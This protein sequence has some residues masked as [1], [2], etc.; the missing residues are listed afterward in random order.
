MMKRISCCCAEDVSADQKDKLDRPIGAPPFSEEEPVDS[1]QQNFPAGSVVV[2]NDAASKDPYLV[3]K[4]YESAVPQAVQQAVPQAEL[5]PPDFTGAWQ[6]SKNKSPFPTV[7][8][9]LR[10]SV[11]M[12]SSDEGHQS[13]LAFSDGQVKML[14]SGLVGSLDANDSAILRW[15]DGDTWN[16]AGFD[17]YWQSKLTSSNTFQIDA[18]KLTTYDKSCGSSWSNSGL[19]PQSP[20]LIKI[21]LDGQ[22]PVT[23]NL[24]QFGLTL[25]W[26]DGDVWARIFDNGG[27]VEAS[28]DKPVQPARRLKAYE[29]G[30]ASPKLQEHIDRQRAE[31][32]AAKRIKERKPPPP[33]FTG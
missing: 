5:Q 16:R 14:D 8:F 12:W 27:F 32:K 20:T 31:D 22:E 19:V 24:D 26:S 30:Q 25:T 28:P 11:V 1:V 29:R 10:G 13:D 4:V 6:D 7:V 9:I 18:A 21:V 23:G 33:G 2:N 17:G 15:S 3:R